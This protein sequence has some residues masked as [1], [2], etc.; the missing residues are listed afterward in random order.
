MSCLCCTCFFFQKTPDFIDQI[1]IR[2]H[3]KTVVIKVTA[4]TCRVTVL[5]QNNQGVHSTLPDHIKQFGVT[6]QL[7]SQQLRQLI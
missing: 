4:K 1:F 6:N 7:A 3:D 2:L 5:S